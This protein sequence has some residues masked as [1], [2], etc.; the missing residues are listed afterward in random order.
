[1]GMG[2]GKAVGCAQDV[3]HPRTAPCAA[4][5]RICAKGIWGCASRRCTR[6]D[7]TSVHR[8]NFHDAPN[9]ALRTP[10]HEGWGPNVGRGKYR[11]SGRKI[12]AGGS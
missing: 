10:T 4:S 2:G 8:S 12:R 1:M 9:R 6:A 11:E 7:V 5:P 3:T